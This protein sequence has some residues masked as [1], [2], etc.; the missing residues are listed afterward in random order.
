M[1]NKKGIINYDS[2][3]IIYDDISQCKKLLATASNMTGVKI[4]CKT[5]KLADEKNLM[6]NNFD[7]IVKRDFIED[8][9]RKLELDNGYVMKF[10]DIGSNFDLGYC[11]TLYAAQGR[12]LK[13][14]YYCREDNKFLQK[15]RA[16]YTLISRLEQS[17]K[18]EKID[19]F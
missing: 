8:G 12:T 15:G 1:L 16:L 4:L 11:V 2:E 14:F 7:Y 6:Y 5:N 9:I 19:C 13:S 3:D 10:S 18:K 17:E